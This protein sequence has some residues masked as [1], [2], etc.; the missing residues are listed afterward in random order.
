MPPASLSRRAVER[1]LDALRVELGQADQTRL[2]ALLPLIGHD[3]RIPLGSTLTALFPGQ[4]RAAALTALRQMRARLAAA[5]K[6]AA[7]KFAL[8]A[9]TQTRASPDQRWCWF[10]GED[11]AAEAATGIR[12]VGNTRCGAYRPGRGADR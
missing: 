2:A 5:A 7:Q 8:E 6:E 12:S 4:K 1:N 10:T 9:D 11:R 3:S